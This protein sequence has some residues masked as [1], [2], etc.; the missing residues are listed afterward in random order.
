MTDVE[1]TTTGTLTYRGTVYPWELDHMGHMNVRHYVGKFDS[2]T[3]ALFAELG[4]T[5]TYLQ[6]NRRGMAA[7]EMVVRYLRELNAGDLVH[8]HTRLVE[9]GDRKI[10]FEHDMIEEETGAVAATCRVTGVHIDT[11][12][13]KSVRFEEAIRA[14]LLKRCDRDGT[15]APATV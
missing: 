7:V 11:D 3:W 10:V 9:V 15:A 5:R 14:H 4:M 6:D 2:A 13:R 8:T 12:R 1:A